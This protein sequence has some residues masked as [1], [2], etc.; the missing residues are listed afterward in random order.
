MPP[1]KNVLQTD[2]IVIFSAESST[3]RAPTFLI[4]S[5]TGRKDFA[6]NH[7]CKRQIPDGVHPHWCDLLMALLLAANV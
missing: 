4:N 1:P 7:L 6:A 2:C 5:V 3:T